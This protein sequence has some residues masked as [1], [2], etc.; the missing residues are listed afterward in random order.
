MARHQDQQ[1]FF[2]RILNRP[3][4]PR[5]PFKP[6]RYS[7]PA[8][9]TLLSIWLR[10]QSFPGNLHLSQSVRTVEERRLASNTTVAESALAS[11]TR[12]SGDSFVPCKT[13]A[14]LAATAVF[15]ITKLLAVLDLVHIS[16]LGTVLDDGT[17]VRELDPVVAPEGLDV[18]ESHG[19]PSLT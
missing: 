17:T 12:L 16:S 3:I 11:R 5:R 2:I 10:L 6:R 9:T 15:Q 7:I 4:C 13:F 19:S 18:V 8:L 14:A 1:L